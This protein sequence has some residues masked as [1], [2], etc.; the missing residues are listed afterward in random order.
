MIHVTVDKVAFYNKM[1]FVVLLR[2]TTSRKVLP[3]FIGAPEAQS[4]AFFMEGVKIPRPLTHDLFKNVMDNL[5]CRMKRVEICDLKD[6]TFYAKLLLETNGMHSEIDARPSDAIA[7]A[8]RFSAPIYVAEHVLDA[9]GVFVEKDMKQKRDS[10][11]KNK[12]HSPM[13]ILREEI[14]KAIKD[15]RYED[16]AK[17]RDELKKLTHHSN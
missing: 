5:E 13:E 16:A 14:N 7:L 2:S 17:L 10:E 4:I 8:L 3:I 6:N 15:E 1:G 12:K 11:H 9:A